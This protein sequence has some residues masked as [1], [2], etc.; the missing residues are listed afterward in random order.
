MLEQ[1]TSAQGRWGHGPA[2]SATVQHLKPEWLLQCCIPLH[3]LLYHTIKTE[4]LTSHQHH[5]RVTV[6]AVS[7]TGH[8]LIVFVYY[9]NSLQ[10]YQSSLL[11]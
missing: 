5:R 7:H 11:S 4:A 1:N 2:D 6:L 3:I 8:H 10:P 9:R